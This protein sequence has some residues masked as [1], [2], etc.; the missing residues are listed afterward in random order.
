LLNV[1]PALQMLHFVEPLIGNADQNVFLVTVCGE[2]RNS[3]VQSEPDT[4][5]HRLYSGTEISADAAG[6]RISLLGIGMH[7]Q[8]REFVAANAEGIV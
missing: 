5:L 4:C 1:G 6:Q 7:K 2:D 3:E 8:E